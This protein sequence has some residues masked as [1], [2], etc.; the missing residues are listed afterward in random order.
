MEGS[1][2]VTALIPCAG[3][4]TRYSDSGSFPR[5]KHLIPVEWEGLRRPMVGHVLRG[6]P[7]SVG[8]V[9]LGVQ[10][11][12]AAMTRDLPV[13]VCAVGTSLGQADTLRQMLNAELDGTDADG[14]CLVVNCDAVIRSAILGHLVHAVTMRPEYC[15]ACCV[16]RTESLGFSYVDRVPNPRSFAEKIRLSPWGMSG[17]WAFRSMRELREAV[18]LAMSAHTEIGLREEVYLSHALNFLSGPFLAWQIDPEHDIVDWNTPEALAA[19]GARLV[20]WAG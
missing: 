17:A 6:L 10:T 16:Q 1:R 18:K 14:P 15:M 8:R 13:A 2:R 12:Y 5:A 4:G 7:G 11:D 19:S 20:S 9:V 3:N